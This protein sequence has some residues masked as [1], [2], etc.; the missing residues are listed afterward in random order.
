ME[1]SPGGRETQIILDKYTSLWPC[2]LF[3]TINIQTLSICQEELRSF[4][5]GVFCEAIRRKSSWLNSST[6]RDAM[7]VTSKSG[8]QT[9]SFSVFKQKFGK[10]TGAFKGFK[11]HFSAITINQEKWSKSAHHHRAN[12]ATREDEEIVDEKRGFVPSDVL[13]DPNKREF[14][15]QLSKRMWMEKEKFLSKCRVL[16]DS[17]DQ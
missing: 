17:S 12:T 16:C 11:Q 14:L 1:K 10:Q 2:R 4:L 5:P 15:T 7:A 6:R 3:I 13:N 8:N 9:E